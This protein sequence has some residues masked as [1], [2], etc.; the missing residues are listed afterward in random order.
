MNL[1]TFHLNPIDYIHRAGDSVNLE[2]MKPF[3]PSLKQL[4]HFS[5]VMLFWWADKHDNPTSRDIKQTEPP[6]AAGRITWVF[7][8]Q[9]EYCPNPIAMTTCKLLVLDE[10]Q[11]V[12]HIANIDAVVGTPL[13]DLKAN[14]PVCDRVQDAHKPK[15][16][17]DWP[18]WMR[19]EG[20]GL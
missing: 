3:R 17:S 9:A 1:E 11:G 5:H 15:W 2:I 6:Y 19:E 10:E 7:A 16:H 20:L 4:D 13:V 12:V 18:E 14:F 8:T